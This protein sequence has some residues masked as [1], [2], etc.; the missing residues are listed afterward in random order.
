MFLNKIRRIDL[1]EYSELTKEYTL[2]SV[3]T[4]R[5][6]MSAVMKIKNIELFSLSNKEKIVGVFPVNVIKRG[7]VR[8]FLPPPFTPYFNLL[9]S[10]VPDKEREKMRFLE[11]TIGNYVSFLKAK[12]MY[13]SV[14]QSP[15]FD[16]SR[17][18]S[19]SGASVSLRYTY[20]YSN[21]QMSADSVDRMLKNR[22]IG[23][24]SEEYDFENSYNM[25]K[26]SYKNKPPVKLKEYLLLME[27]LKEKNLIKCF[28]SKDAN[29]TF[30]L[31]RE[32]STAYTY[33]ISGRETA[34]LIFSAAT[35]GLLDGF[36]ID[37][38]GA[39]TKRISLYKSMFNPKIKS[40]FSISGYHDFFKKF[41]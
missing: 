11:E 27:S 37:F 9:L 6:Y 22:N 18:F 16:D 23:E 5:D 13:F 24:I 4:E 28:S 15:D 25:L 39:N 10:S 7:F 36:S 20:I 3:F 29:V 31:D 32:S 38:H 21:N 19:W 34:P 17:H 14:P 12:F 33:N 41:N 8:I 30:L 1:A 35:R 2:K 40:Y 26:V